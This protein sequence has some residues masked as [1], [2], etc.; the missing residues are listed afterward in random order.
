MMHEGKLQLLM[1]IDELKESHQRLV[2]QFSQAIT[3]FP[4]IPGMLHVEGEGREWAVVCHGEPGVARVA[5]ESAGA[6]I[7]EESA[8]SLDTVFVSRVKGGSNIPAAT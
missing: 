4:T 2:V 5:L 3:S 8:P 6:R 7:I 1:P